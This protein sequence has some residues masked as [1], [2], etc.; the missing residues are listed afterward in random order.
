MPDYETP[1][2]ET[3]STMNDL[4]RAGKIRYVGISNYAS[5]QICQAL[6]LCERHSWEPPVVAQQMYN[7]LAR[8]IEQEHL[9]FLREFGIGLI[10]Y[11]PLAAGL[12]TGK[13]KDIEHPLEGTRFD[14][15]QMYLDP[16]RPSR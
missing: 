15:N 9:A 14:G 11:N 3:L 13:H 7:L 1:L 5:W 10:V 12:L 6:W 16:R 4:V 2:A 8:G